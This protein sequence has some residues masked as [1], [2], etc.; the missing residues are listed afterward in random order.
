MIA[1]SDALQSR[2]NFAN[3]RRSGVELP[4]LSPARTF[5]V[6]PSR[7]QPALCKDGLARLPC[8]TEEDHHAELVIQ[9]LHQTA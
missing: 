2:G 1:P 8:L 7:L 6:S 3:S 9:L 4:N 5:K